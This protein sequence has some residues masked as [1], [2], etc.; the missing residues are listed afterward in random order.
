VS[1]EALWA[2]VIYFPRKLDI[3]NYRPYWLRRKLHIDWTL[4]VDINI[5]EGMGRVQRRRE[6]KGHGH[7]RN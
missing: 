3:M 6:G 7:G 5:K 2:V 1:D 4:N